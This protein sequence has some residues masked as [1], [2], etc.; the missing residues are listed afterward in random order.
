MQH[1]N[2]YRNSR[3]GRLFIL[4][5]GPSLLDNDLTR[6]DK[7]EVMTINRSWRDVPGAM[8]HLASGDLT[9]IRQP[10]QNILFYG[11]ESM[12]PPTRIAQF[13]SNIIL[14]R[15]QGP[16][17]IFK[18]VS[19][20]GIPRAFDLRYGWN[21][22]A[23]GVLAIYCAWW[24]GYRDLYLM[25]YDGYGNHYTNNWRGADVPDHVKLVPEFK[26]LVRKLLEFDSE[27]Q[28]TNMNHNTTYKDLGADNYYII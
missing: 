13:P 15:M 26:S 21:V 17:H 11:T 23:G 20:V 25:G 28:I 16:G 8:F 10:P 3:S 7:Y 12:Y 6:L 18:E 19:Y 2:N 24:L 4:G 22:T 1:I 27:L 14:I 5:N 9:G